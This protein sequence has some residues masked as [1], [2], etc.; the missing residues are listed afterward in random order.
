MFIEELMPEHSLENK[1]TE[2]K[3]IIE[4]GKSKS[5]KNLETGCLT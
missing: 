4:E 2:Y 3:G 1:N 5:G